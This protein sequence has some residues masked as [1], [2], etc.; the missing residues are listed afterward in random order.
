M[1]RNWNAGRQRN[2]RE[3]LEAVVITRGRGRDRET[4]S[5][6]KVEHARVCVC[7][8][9]LVCAKKQA[10]ESLTEQ[11]HWSTEC[12]SSE[13]R[14]S[15][16]SPVLIM[17]GL[18]LVLCRVGAEWVMMSYVRAGCD[19]FSWVHGGSRST[20]PRT[21][22]LGSGYP[23]S[24]PL[25]KHEW[26]EMISDPE[27]VVRGDVCPL[28]DESCGC[29]CEACISVAERLS[30]LCVVWIGKCQAEWGEYLKQVAVTSSK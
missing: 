7:V 18:M 30:S 26:D 10:D 25:I 13:K 1:R 5:D 19:V 29:L 20:L 12:H 8:R 9:V 22:D 6:S 21:T 17:C 28:R 2:Q 24:S 27:S 4:Q 11:D 16:V 14:Q 3:G 23:T 15:L